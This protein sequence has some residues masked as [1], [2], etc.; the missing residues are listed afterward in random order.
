VTGK[1]SRRNKSI[2]GGQL[3]W[4]WS[5]VVSP[6]DICKTLERSLPPW[7]NG[8]A[9]HSFLPPRRV[10]TRLKAFKGSSFGQSFHLHLGTPAEHQPIFFSSRPLTTYVRG[11]TSVNIS[12]LLS[13]RKPATSAQP[14]C[15]AHIAPIHSRTP[16]NGP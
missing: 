14:R 12:L 10:L 15:S 9:R 4:L 16:T 8:N 6:G 5:P 11:T 1:R 13:P 3:R 2:V 7:T